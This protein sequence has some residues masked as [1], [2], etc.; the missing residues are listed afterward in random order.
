METGFLP[1]LRVFFEFEQLLRDKTERARLSALIAWQF[2]NLGLLGL[3]QNQLR[4]SFPRLLER[5]L[6]REREQWTEPLDSSFRAWLIIVEY[7]MGKLAEIGIPAFPTFLDLK[8]LADPTSG[9]F[10]YPFNKSRNNATILAM[11][12]AKGNLDEFWAL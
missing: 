8:G 7:P 6:S 9:K 4:I 5:T 1:N 12:K 11:Q 2:T 3:L 10:V